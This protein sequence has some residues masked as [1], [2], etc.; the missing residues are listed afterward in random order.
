MFARLKNLLVGKPDRVAPA[1]ASDLPTQ[2][3]PKPP[4]GRGGRAIPSYFT[5]TK[6]DQNQKISRND[7]RLSRTD[8]LSYRSSS[9][10]RKVIRDLGSTSPEISSA[11]WAMLRLGIPE[12]F[13]AVAVS[14]VDG[15][16]DVEATRLLQQIVQR[17]DVLPQYDE[18]YTPTGGISSISQSLAKDLLF[19]GG[20]C[21]EL[22][23]DKSRL[24]TFIQP[25]SY[26]SVE[27]K[28]DLSGATRGVRPIQEVSG[29]EID[30]DIPTIAIM[31]LDQDLTETYAS[32]PLESAIKAVLAKEEF[33][34]DVSRVLK[35]AIQ[36]R[37][38]VRID[39]DRFRRTMSPEAQVDP[40]KAVEEMDATIRQ[41]ETLVNGL[42]PED[43]LVHFDTV[44]F[45]VE[46]PSNGGLAKEYETL[47]HML[48]SRLITGSKSMGTVLGFQGGSS[49]IASTEVMLFA[50]SVSSSIK[51]T[52]D[53][54]YSRLF[55]TA[56]RL[57]GLDVVVRFRYADIDLRPEADLSAFR[58][59][60]QV[61]VL[62]QLSLGLITDEEACLKLTGKL[63]PPGY[64]PLSG[65]HFKNPQAVAPQ[66]SSNSGSTLNQNLNGDT[67]AQGPG[68]NKK[69]NVYPLE[70]VV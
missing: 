4:S 33:R 46:S 25:F 18:G 15:S 29:E 7:R 55:T 59:T 54:M 8:I 49:N 27:F 42:A 66:E 3:P 14:A 40:E 35:R 58:H 13:T 50:K 64:T 62:E 69:A 20:C 2:P 44:T 57:F 61:I 32:S 63:P 34:N 45:E 53:S 11:V 67:P 23:L 38:K 26:S 30:L 70:S 24:P 41:L 37:Q 28:P 5:S 48:N 22:V 39:E 17:V 47:E 9:D 36:P 16:V 65:T 6:P 31:T 68:Q 56:L 19:T 51:E 43:A 1:A 52:L 60:Q 10:S 21:A 12:K